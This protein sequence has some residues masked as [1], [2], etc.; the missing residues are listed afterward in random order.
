M[1]DVFVS[2]SS[3]DR[4]RVRPIVEAL[5]DVGWTVWWDREI[6]A[7]TAFDRE[8]EKAIDVAKCVVVVWS[9]DSVESEWVRNEA[10]EG[11]EKNNLV[12]VLI[13]PVRPPLAFR[14]IQTIDLCES[15]DNIAQLQDS[16]AGFAAI[17]TRGSDVTTF[18][19]REK[20]LAIINSR[21]NQLE[22]AEGNF[23]LLSG[24][25]GV[26]KTRLT[27]VAADLAKQKGYLVLTG[28]CLD[29]DG[30]AP[31]QPLIDQI[32]QALRIG[33]P[34]ALRQTLGENAPEMSKL[35]PELRQK[36]DDIPEPVTLPP[37]QERRYLLH[38]VGEFLHRAAEG[39]PMVLI[40]EDLH[41]ADS[42]TCILLRYLADR[43]KTSRVLMLGTYRET[44]LET[45][46]PF[47]RTLQE[48]NRER[49][50]EDIQVTRFDRALVEV[51]LQR[52]A[53]QSP[54]AELV[55]LV[56]SETE[57]NPFFVEELFRHLQESGKLFSESGEFASAIEI[58]DT[59]VPRG[60]RLI[61]GERL[62]KITDDCRTALTVGAV[63]G[64]QFNFEVLLAAAN[65]LDEDDLLDAMDEAMSANLVTDQS[66]DRQAIYGFAQEQV[67]Q[68]L[69]S[70]LSVPRRQRMHLRVA[71]AIETYAGT[72]ASKFS[73]EIAHHL[74]QAGAA[75][76][77]DRTISYLLQAAERAVQAIAFED[78]L[79]HFDSALSIVKD[80]K[81]EEVADI[82]SRRA[83]ALQGLERFDEALD[84]LKQAIDLLPP[85]DLKDDFILKRCRVLLD[86]WR[87]KQ[88][89]DDLLSLLDRRKAASDREKELETQQWVARALY[90]K[91]LDETGYAEKAIDAYEDTIALARQLNNKT[92]LARALIASAQL[93][94]YSPTYLSK[95]RVHLDEAEQL[96]AELKSED[97]EIEVAT[98]R[99]SPFL[100]TSDDD[101]GE[102]VLARLE[103]R[104]DPIRLNAHYFRMMWA[105]YSGGLP[106]RCV[107]IC[108][109][110]TELAY[111]IGTLPVQ[112]PTIKGM[113]LMDLGRFKDSWA[114]IGE[115][116]NDEDHRFGAALQ[117]LGWMQYELEVGAFDDAIG[118]APHVIEESRAL[119][120]VWMLNWVANS[121]AMVASLP[122]NENRIEPI[123]AIIE[124]TGYAPGSIGRASLALCE[125]DA[126]AALDRLQSRLP[127]LGSLL[128]TRNRLLCLAMMATCYQATGSWQEM[129][130]VIKQALTI[131]N[132]SELK[133]MQWRL[134][135]L[136]AKAHQELGAAEAAK[137]SLDQAEEIWRLTADAIPDDK[138]RDAYALLAERLG[139]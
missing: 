65:K 15:L 42:S 88:A 82:H 102:A 13:E 14:R 40:F 94:D 62:E 74:Y 11:L 41:W 53:K 136:Q 57:G 52:Q 24:E 46:R 22:R 91:S 87:G 71:D 104:R 8:I 93:V 3:K 6:G 122:G 59:E 90:V 86:I 28:H 27:Q 78:A 50:V 4:D 134:L 58:K 118:R 123:K 92:E 106:H 72:N 112:Y 81:T 63:I 35:M 117:A 138:H 9:A 137:D 69:L 85:G 116:I 83:A 97:F 115:E 109:A 34:E 131:T 54:P 70:A 17:P 33:P 128:E 103:N 49:L 51:M 130:D 68:T 56:Y 95:A 47:S 121:L 25:A 107:E 64:R 61:I 2:Y 75:A 23:M 133:P 98:A 119:S 31:Y 32:E 7:G 19:G 73:G 44:D 38:G 139:I 124:S 5:N 39:Q 60:V 79:R 16:I 76:D 48:L 43:L 29:M 1:V 55:D 111:R 36:F 135:T 120:R 77:E 84:T 127:R 113:A 45:Q 101:Y 105:T 20:E 66:K 96:A 89:V 108:D 12:P 99:L 114:A 30:A 80:N 129:L 21:I 125:G 110:G 126:E 26:G 18:V 37:E 100:S 10:N 67:R 132:E